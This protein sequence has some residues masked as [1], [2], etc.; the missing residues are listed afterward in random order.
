[1][2]LSLGYRAVEILRQNIIKKQDV[3]EISA[4]LKKESLPVYSDEQIIQFLLACN[5]VVD[6][7]KKTI[8]TYGE[9][10]NSCNEIFSNKNVT[11]ADLQKYLKVAEICVLPERTDDGCVVLFNRLVDTNYKNFELGAYFTILTM[12]IES[13][14]FEYP[15]NGL[16]IV[17][18]VSGTTWKHMFCLRLDLIR[19]YSHFLQEG[20]PVRLRKVCLINSSPILDTFM[21]VLRPFTKSEVMEKVNTF[22]AGDIESFYEKCLPKRLL[23]LDY[24]G[25]MPS[26]KILH[27]NQVEK[28]KT[29]GN[30]FDAEEK[31]RKLE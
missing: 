31:Q 13:A 23:P 7:T 14:L 11:R 19:I 10:S 18:D 27:E 8:Q 24:G 9:I 30:Y 17:I 1:M 3:D 5:S 4:W 22:K 15:V 12:A 16:I 25:E 6:A 29:L 28:F 20:L 2:Q 21:T 26:V